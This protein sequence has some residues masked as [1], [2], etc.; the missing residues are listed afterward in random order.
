MVLFTSKKPKEPT[1]LH[2]E[3]SAPSVVSEVMSL[4]NGDTKKQN[5]KHNR[6]VKK[7]EN[8]IKKR[9][10]LLSLVVIF[11]LLLVG[12]LVGIMYWSTRQDATIKNEEEQL[13]KLSAELNDTK[14][15][16]STSIKIRKKTELVQECYG[17]LIPFTIRKVWRT[18]PCSLLV[19]LESEHG[20]VTVAY[21]RHEGSTESPDIGFR[22]ANPTKYVESKMKGREGY[23]FVVFKNRE[24]NRY[25][26]SAFLQKDLF[27]V[28]ITLSMDFPSQYDSEFQNMLSS[29]Y[30][31]DGCRL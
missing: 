27:T 7:P 21:R 12:V 18:Q 9:R 13:N 31:V 8:G 1:S 23:D 10:S 6:V 19:F 16:N 17:I 5:I 30:C 11:L 15:P 20:T 29:F 24:T 14:Y 25:E 26:K 2:N 4:H 22:R 3:S 28:S